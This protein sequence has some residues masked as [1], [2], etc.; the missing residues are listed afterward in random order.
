MLFAMGGGL[1]VILSFGAFL[2]APEYLVGTWDLVPVESPRSDTSFAGPMIVE[3]SGIYANLHFK[4]G[5]TLRMKLR[6]QPTFSS[7]EAPTSTMMENDEWKLEISGLRGARERH[8]RLIGPQRHEWS[9]HRRTPGETS[10]AAPEP[11]PVV[12]TETEVSAVGPSPA[13]LPLADDA[14]P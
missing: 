13:T 8:I 1:W 11:E 4:S 14:R 7:D 3:Q 2:Q 6:D 10:P 5:E 9:A 12:Q